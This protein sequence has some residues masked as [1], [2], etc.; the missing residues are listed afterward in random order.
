VSSPTPPFTDTLRLR[1]P[2]RV[3]GPDLATRSSPPEEV[4]Q[5]MAHADA[6]NQRLRERGYLIGFALS[7]DS[8]RLRI[9]LRD[10]SGTLLRMLSAEEAIELAAGGA[11]A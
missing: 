7:A 3:L 8:R 6:I 11:P 4:L 1:A 9:E 10:T 2:A 5:Q